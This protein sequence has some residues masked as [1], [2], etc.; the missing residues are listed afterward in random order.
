MGLNLAACQLK[1]GAFRDVIGICS[2]VG[3]LLSACIEF[4]LYACMHACIC[5]CFD[6]DYVCI[7]LCMP[8]GM[9]V[10]MEG[11]CF[12]VYVTYLFVQS[13][14]PTVF[15]QLKEKDRIEPFKKGL[16]LR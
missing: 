16:L 1:L 3:L 5:V 12:T 4:V 9:Y 14:V 11:V 7:Y 10:C 6:A 2:T 8:V 15:L 13:S